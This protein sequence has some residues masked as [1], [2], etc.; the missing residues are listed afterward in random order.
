MSITGTV[1]ELAQDTADTP[2][3][4]RP[5]SPFDLPDFVQQLLGYAGFAYVV[6]FVTLAANTARFGI[7]VQEFAK[8]LTIWA[9]AIPTITVFLTILAHRSLNE[10]HPKTTLRRVASDLFVLAVCI[11]LGRA[12]LWYAGW[13][14]RLQSQA[15]YVRWFHMFNWS[16]AWQAHHPTITNTLGEIMLFGYLIFFYARQRNMTWA[17]FTVKLREYLSRY[18]VSAVMAVLLVLYIWVGYPQWPQQYGFGRPQSARLLVS[19]DGALPLPL[20]DAAPATGLRLTAPI[21]LLF[22]TD[23][24]YVVQYWVNGQAKIVSIDAGEVKGIVWK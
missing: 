5:R 16:I 15:F 8:P 4:P 14:I 22:Q 7:P 1:M 13:A 11:A 21:D 9:G 24:Q 10:G 17:E 19:A 23:S 3:T 6:G 2:Q 18:A 12:Y 20:A